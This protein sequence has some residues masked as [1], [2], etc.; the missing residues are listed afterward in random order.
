MKKTLLKVH[1]ITDNT[2]NVKSFEDI[3]NEF[4]SILPPSV[5]KS[6]MWLML[7]ASTQDIL[8]ELYGENLKGQK[9]Y[10]SYDVLEAELA[11][12]LAFIHDRNKNV[13]NGY[14]INIITP[15]ALEMKDRIIS[16]CN[17]LNIQPGLP[18]KYIDNKLKSYNND[19]TYYIVEDNEPSDMGWEK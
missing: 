12:V 3:Y 2:Q 17:Q 4:K 19:V 13:F 11:L 10:M 15:E 8:E 7:N 16:L 6:K 14:I 5:T 9:K 18:S 1:I